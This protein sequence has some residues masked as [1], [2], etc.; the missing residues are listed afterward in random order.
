MLISK[1]EARHDFSRKLKWD[2]S[3]FS[4]EKVR[5]D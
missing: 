4:S 1:N 2:P 5:G 3:D